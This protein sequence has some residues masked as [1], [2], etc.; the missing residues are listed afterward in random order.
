MSKLNGKV[1]KFGHYSKIQLEKTAQDLNLAMTEEQLSYCASYYRTAE[2]RDPLISELRF[3]D[4]LASKLATAPATLAIEKFATNHRNVAETYADLIEKRA[5]LAPETT[6][7]P[8]VTEIFNIANAY[9]ERSGKLCSLSNRSLLLEDGQYTQHLSDGSGC[10]GI[11]GARHQ[12]RVL[13]KSGLTGRPETGDLFVLFQPKNSKNQ[14]VYQKRIGDFFEAIGNTASWKL[15]DTVQACGLLPSILSQTNTGFRINLSALSESDSELTLAPLT[16]AF[17]GYHYAILPANDADRIRKK[18]EECGIRTRFFAS[19]TVANRISFTTEDAEVFSLNADFLRSILFIKAASAKYPDE[20]KSADTVIRHRPTTSVSCAYLHKQVEEPTTQA[21]ELDKTLLAAAYCD[22]T[23]AFY[24]NAFYTALCPIV[25]LA[26]AGR[27]YPEQRLAI[28][29]TIP[30]LTKD[31]EQATGNCI[32]SMLGIYRLQAELGIPAAATSLI[33]DPAISD[34]QITAFSASSGFAVSNTYQEVGNKIYCFQ[35]K[36][37]ANGLPDFTSLRTMLR[38]LTARSQSGAIVSA[39]VLC[40]ESVTDGL[41]KMNRPGLYC[42]IED[43]TIASHGSLPIAVLAE[44][45]APIQGLSPIG[46]VEAKE[47]E[48]EEPLPPESYEPISSMIWS[49]KTEFTLL[50][51]QNDIDAKILQNI[52]SKKGGSAHLFE[53]GADNAGA[54]SRSLLGTHILIL[55][56]DAH[57]PNTEQVHFALDTMLRAGGVIWCVNRTD[58]TPPHDRALMIKHGIPEE[59][60]DAMIERK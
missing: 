3:L 43:N 53:S 7:P 30:E 60:L 38:N 32:A 13:P 27:T 6:T 11:S 57:L 54:I 8:T 56:K 51:N 59:M 4:T 10:L 55:C 18:A 33:T 15:L 42:H 2:K 1:R 45:N 44:C 17:T 36:I 39:L 22:P 29:M 20:K 58:F 21:R 40:N 24:T 23:D 41:L 31:S 47:E 49:D 28:G 25:T 37:D 16:E 9:L 46:V 5:T 50:C 52:I 19:A 12:I 34:P 14:L 35:P 26:A 48:S